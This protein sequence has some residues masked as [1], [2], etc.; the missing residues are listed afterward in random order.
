MLTLGMQ[1]DGGPLIR[2]R[3]LGWVG[4]MRVQEISCFGCSTTESFS[5]FG[6]IRHSMNFGGR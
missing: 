6:E 5:M 4:V 3:R 1:S 2:I